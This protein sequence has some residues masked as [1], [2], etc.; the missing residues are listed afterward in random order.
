MEDFRE[1]GELWPQVRASLIDGLDRALRDPQSS[2]YLTAQSEARL[3]GLGER[4][5]ADDR[6]KAVAFMRAVGSSHG[7]GVWGGV[8]GLEKAGVS[9]E[10]V[11]PLVFKEWL[12]MLDQ[13]A[14]WENP[15]W[16]SKLDE[17]RKRGADK[18]WIWLSWAMK[19]S[20]AGWVNYGKEGPTK[21]SQ[22]SPLGPEEQSEMARVFLKFKRAAESSALR[23]FKTGESDGYERALESLFNSGG[24]GMVYWKT[25]AEA[26]AYF[27][28]QEQRGELSKAAGP[29]V[30]RAREIGRRV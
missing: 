16:V 26:S 6:W 7:P 29:G 17:E 22:R 4:A 24:Y 21:A 1:Q 8:E 11:G 12:F 15:F 9:W 28:A 3:A 13:T 19:I 30:K 25:M 27:E 18:T 5:M 10:R 14:E 2:A 20:Q 23:A